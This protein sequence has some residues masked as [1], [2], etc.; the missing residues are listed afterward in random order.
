MKVFCIVN[1]HLSQL[2]VS[3]GFSDEEIQS[4]QEEKLKVSCMER[5]LTLQSNNRLS[6]IHFPAEYKFSSTNEEYPI[7]SGLSFSLRLNSCPDPPSQSGSSSNRPNL[8]LLN[9]WIF[10]HNHS[11]NGEQHTTTFNNED[12]AQS[13]RSIESLSEMHSFLTEKSVGCRILLESTNAPGESLC[14]QVLSSRCQTFACDF[15]HGSC[16]Q[17]EPRSVCLFHFLHVSSSDDTIHAQELREWRR[18]FSVEWIKVQESVFQ[19]ILQLMTSSTSQTISSAGH[20][21]PFQL[22]FLMI[23]VS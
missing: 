2:R 8:E 11:C 3:L 19:E 13:N 20:S 10:C 12:Q 23:H 6:T 5:C 22:G 14:I 9:D 16:C 21:S 15:P 17:V 7:S 4:S 18:S 1:H